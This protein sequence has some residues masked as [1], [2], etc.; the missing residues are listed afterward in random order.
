MTRSHPSALGAQDGGAVPFA[1]LSCSTRNLGDDIQ[2]L[3]ALQF[4]PPDLAFVDRDR[5][6]LFRPKRPHRAVLN[7]W[8][9]HRPAY[10]PPS[11]LLEP[12]VTSIHF[13]RDD[14]YGPQSVEWLRRQSVLRPVGARDLHT[15]A[16]ARALGID[17]FHS[18]CLTMTLRI[19]SPPERSGPPCVVDLPDEAVE[20]V[21]RR[22]GAVRTPTHRISRPRKLFLTR[23]RR[24]QAAA[25]LLA[26][27][28]GSRAVVT[29][30]LHAALPAMALGTPVLFVTDDPGKGRFAG[31]IEHMHA[32]NLKDFLAGL[33]DFDFAAPP[34]N[35]DGWHGMARRLA[36]SVTAFTGR[37]GR[38]FDLALQEILARGG[39][40]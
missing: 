14:L 25:D 32:V 18:G 28:A 33:F 40:L 34:P 15:M 39:R 19:S 24:L 9:T 38:P 17:A 8:F 36:D 16:A 1:S 7:G 11:A 3:A 35:P 22:A 26:L 23:H 6:S 37:A 10:W 30:R 4:L 13:A 20:L 31:L 27:Y 21:R 5:L 2:V 12:L 29:R